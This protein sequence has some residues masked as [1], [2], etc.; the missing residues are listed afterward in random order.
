MTPRYQLHRRT[1]SP[2]YFSNASNHKPLTS[3]P[4]RSQRQRHRKSSPMTGILSTM[5]NIDEETGSDVD[6]EELLTPEYMEGG[7]DP[8]QLLLPYCKVCFKSSFSKLTS[9]HRSLP[10]LIVPRRKI[11]LSTT[12]VAKPLTLQLSS[13]KSLISRAISVRL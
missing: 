11:W 4:S 5:W 9:S 6:G 10:L 7:I 2:S 12:W 1:S 13:L 3:K 8:F